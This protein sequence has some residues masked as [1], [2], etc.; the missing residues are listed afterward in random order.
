MTG[1]AADSRRDRGAVLVLTLLLTIV[2]AAIVLALATYAATG[3]RTSKVTAE[4]TESNA[5]ASSAMTWAIEQFAKK[6]IKPEDSTCDDPLVGFEPP[7]GFVV[8]STVTLACERAPLSDGNNPQV[9]LRS[10]AETADGT[11]RS[12]E[13]LLEVPAAQYTTQVNSW[14]GS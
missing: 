1:P 4:R 9:V 12:I 5:D 13:V 14:V 2:L 7:S 8:G 10:V 3:L 6:Q 11:S